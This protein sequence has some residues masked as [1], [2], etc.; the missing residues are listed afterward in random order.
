MEIALSLVSLI[1]GVLVAHTYYKKSALENNLQYSNLKNILAEIIIEHKRTI[2]VLK[3]K[4]PI[5]SDKLEN[6][7]KYFLHKLDKDG[8]ID[9]YG[10]IKCPKCNY[11]N[12]IGI[13]DEEGAV[14]YTYDC[15]KCKY[16]DELLGT[17]L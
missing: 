15:P 12:E 14:S 5:L 3:T 4:D 11:E 2:A 7:F 9:I 16:H 17:V 10:S 13:K 1:I 8:G 6:D